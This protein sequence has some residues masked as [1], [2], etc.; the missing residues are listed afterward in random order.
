MGMTMGVAK[1]RKKPRIPAGAVPPTH[2]ET[3]SHCFAALL[4]R[5]L[6]S[7]L[8]LSDRAPRVSWDLHVVPPTL[9][10]VM[11]GAVSPPPLPGPGSL[12][13]LVTCVQ[14]CTPQLPSAS[15][16]CHLC[17]CLGDR[18]PP[19]G[20]AASVSLDCVLYGDPLSPGFAPGHLPGHGTQQ[21][22]RPWSVSAAPRVMP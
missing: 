3:P 19:L 21:H 8:V 13:E 15:T 11:G 6:L 14:S 17:P 22:F 16:L 5:W 12:E 4:G 1:A 20:T 10:L 9:C 2:Q 7:H 18:N